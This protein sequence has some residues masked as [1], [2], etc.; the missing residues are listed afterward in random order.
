MIYAH[1]PFCE[2]KC[3]YCSF[4]SFA[5]PNPPQ[6]AYIAALIRQFEA[7]LALSEGDSF[8][9]LYIGGGS[10]SVFDAAG[11]E[12]FFAK[13]SPFLRRGAEVTI[14]VNPNSLSPKWAKTA[15]SLGVNRISV[16]VQSFDDR[17]LK[18]L[19]RAHNGE[20]ARAAIAGAV[21]AGFERISVDLIYGV[22]GDSIALLESDL[23]NA[24]AL[25]ATH[26]SAYCLTIEEGTPFAAKPQTAIED[27]G[28]A[29]AFSRLIEAAG[30]PRYEVSNYGSTPSSHNMGYW[31]GRGYLGLG[32]GAV[33]FAKR[34][35]ASFRYAPPS[36][37]AAYI[38]DPLFK[39]TEII[40]SAT[41]NDERL[42]LGLRCVRGF[43]A[44]VLSRKER[45]KAD[46]LVERGRLIWGENRYF[47]ADFWLADEIWL[48]IKS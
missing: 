19:G 37:P 35:A 18:R 28:L 41:F 2:S 31:E 27:R 10:P 42:M 39:T 38:D 25:G 7:D 13:V 36:D 12:P 11:Y 47:N 32:A 16:G 20:S 30:Y 1:I 44:G 8:G 46:F 45:V 34:G 23:K 40:D 21:Q 14:E 48:Y 15:R 26:I 17:K 43:D 24:K 33:G 4:N 9:S 29:R 3:P 22:A 6:K 5:A